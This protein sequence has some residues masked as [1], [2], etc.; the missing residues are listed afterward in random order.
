MADR[1]YNVLFL[2]SDN[3]ACSLMAEAILNRDGAG[4]FR[5]FSA[6]RQPVHGMAPMVENLLKKLNYPLEPLRSKSWDLFAHPDAP[7]MDFIFTLSDLGAAG[8]MPSWPGTPMTAH[9]GVPDPLNDRRGEAEQAVLVAEVFR[10]LSNRID[11]F[12]NLPMR[13]LD[14]LSLQR[15]LTAIGSVSREPAVV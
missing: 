12:L 9:W 4:R 8:E 2:C 11:I 3:S 1:P 7:P 14:Q 10:M 6:G 5:A 15:R 13:S